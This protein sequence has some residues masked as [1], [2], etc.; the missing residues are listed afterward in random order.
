MSRERVTNGEVA[1]ITGG[2]DGVGRATAEALLRDGWTVV[3]TGRSQARCDATVRDLRER[4]PGATVSSLTGDLSEMASVQRLA[5]AF[6]KEHARLD[7]LLLNANSIT[8]A[9]TRTA[10][11]F[12]A[13]WAVGYLSRV[14]LLW[15]LED[16]LRAAPR[17]NVLTVVGLNLERIDF[18]D[19]ST[20]AGFSSMKALGRWQW[21][22]QVFAR[23][24]NQRVPEVSLNVYMP[25]LVKTKILANEPQ[26]LRLFVK[27]AAALMGV[28][29]ERSGQELA[30]V[31]SVVRSQSIR[32][33]YF[34]RT[35]L[36]APRALKDQPGDGEVLWER[37][38]RW[39]AP[40]LS[41]QST[42]TPTNS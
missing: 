35:K 32:D 34:S 11:G 33:G 19:P 16:L 21:A 27:I 5:A 17:A 22:M 41:A 3:I 28:P 36:Q 30:T 37:T 10:E 38:Q 14:L 2:T 15:S 8:Q 7:L 13:N 23:E 25:G 42:E 29:V 20:P 18:D 12:E 4:V 26:P 31:V 24:W 1:L 9:H 40:W 6:R 39:L